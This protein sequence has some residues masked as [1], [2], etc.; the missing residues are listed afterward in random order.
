MKN[1]KSYKSIIAFHPGSYVE[2]I[3]ENMNISQ[4]E[5]A[6]RLNITEKSLSRL[7]NAED[8]LSNDIARKLSQLSGISIE[9][10]LNLQST[11]D[12]KVMEIEDAEKEDEKSICKNIDFNYFKEHNYV[13]K[14]IYNIDKKIREL[15]KLLSI[16]SLTYLSRMNP[17]VSYRNASGNFDDK[18]I[19]NSNIMLELGIAQASGMSEIKFDKNT[20]EKNIT[21]IKSLTTSPPELFIP[22]LKELF[23][24]CGIVFITL[25]NLRNAKINGAVKRF[26]NGSVLLL[27]SDRNKDLDIFWFSLFHEIGHILSGDFYSD[28]FDTEEYSSQESRAD[29]FAK[30][31]LIQPH[32]YQEFVQKGIFT[33]E[34]VIGFAQAEKIHPG[35]VVGRL[36]KEE[37]ISY[38]C[39]NNLKEKY[40]FQIIENV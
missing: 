20:L 1:E 30:D 17:Q 18:A 15:R 14:G 2:D 9:T 28:Y 29:T 25:P 33:E 32:K 11:Y 39:L 5:F 16:S 34:H 35:I 13:N 6:K 26:K 7:V 24:K 31:T 22:R 36:Q 4:K 19:I 40:D 27:I 38:K 3:I 37:Y 23:S 12:I 21:T 8:K 10:W